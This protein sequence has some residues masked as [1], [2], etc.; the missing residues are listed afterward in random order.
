MPAPPRRSRRLRGDPATPVA[1]WQARHGIVLLRNQGKALPL[2]PAYRRCT[3]PIKPRARM[4]SV[5]VAYDG[6]MQPVWHRAVLVQSPLPTIHTAA[7]WEPGFPELPSPQHPALPA[8]QRA[9][10]T[11]GFS[12]ALR[13]AQHSVHCTAPGDPPPKPEALGL[14]S[15]TG[16]VRLAGSPVETPRLVRC[17]PV[18]PIVQTLC[19][20][21]PSPEALRTAEYPMP[22]G[23]SSG[24]EAQG[25][26]GHPAPWPAWRPASSAQIGPSQPL[27][28]QR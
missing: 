24:A 12:A 21:A 8:V 22:R 6:S 4:G 15:P 18:L 17:A 28:Q 13:C 2:G 14:P 1:L 7:A 25:M 26:I 11:P 9:T 27:L 3:A 5:D 20:S 10:G 16:L 19:Y 23:S